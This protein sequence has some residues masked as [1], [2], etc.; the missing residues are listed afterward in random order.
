MTAFCAFVQQLK[1][2]STRDSFCLKSASSPSS[3]SAFLE[4]DKNLIVLA[5]SQASLPKNKFFFIF[6][7][8]KSKNIR[9]TKFSLR[10]F[11][12]KNV[13]SKTV[14]SAKAHS[15]AEF[16]CNFLNLNYEFFFVFY[17]DT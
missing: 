3:S 14:L 13:E 12:L 2:L 7:S 16:L 11:R 1:R 5:S 17:L 10:K 8:L 4:I 6:K 9:R 15:N